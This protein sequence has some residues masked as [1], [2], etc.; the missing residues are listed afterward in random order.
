MSQGILLATS[1]GKDSTLCLYRLRK[2]GVPV[3]ALLTTV[4]EPYR[5]VSMHGV[6]LELMAAQAE[7]LGIPLDPVFIPDPCSNKEYEERMGERLTFWK[8][9]GV[10]TVAFGDI[11]L[12]DLREYRIKQLKRLGMKGEFPIFGETTKDLS[13]EFLEEGFSAIIACASGRFFP[14]GTAGA[15]YDRSFLERLPGDV[16]PCGENG[17]FHTFVFSGPIFCKPVPF[18]RGEVTI[19]TYTHP[20]LPGDPPVPYEFVDLL[21]VP[22]PGAP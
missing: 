10:D 3:V 18:Q 11:F 21:P 9:Q 12:E 7:S 2:R 1:G 15:L 19:R 8:E 13:R 17:E 6:R 5:R 22:L 16:D 14:P 4:T 20:D